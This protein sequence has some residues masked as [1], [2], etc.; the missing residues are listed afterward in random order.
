[1][2]TLGIRGVPGRTLLGCCGGWFG[3]LELDVLLW[4]AS[5]GSAGLVVFRILLVFFG[6]SSVWGRDVSPKD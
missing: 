4:V 5:S 3:V 6:L 2:E 1:M